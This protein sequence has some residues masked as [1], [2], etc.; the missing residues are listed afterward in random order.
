MPCLRSYPLPPGAEQVDRHSSS[1]WG[2]H[3]SEVVGR[4]RSRRSGRLK[5]FAACLMAF[6]GSAAATGSAAAAALSRPSPG[7]VEAP[8]WPG[9]PPDFVPDPV[10]ES[11]ASTHVSR[12]TMTV[13]G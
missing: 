12:P 2:V 7:H 3:M 13:Y 1:S 8:I 11:G 9:T 4:G 6:A 5:L 10:P